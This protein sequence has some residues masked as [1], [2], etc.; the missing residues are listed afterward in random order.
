MNLF[1]SVNIFIGLFCASLGTDSKYP[2]VRFQ[3]ST[4]VGGVISTSKI[5][6]FCD[7]STDMFFDTIA[8]LLI[9]NTQSYNYTLKAS[10]K[11]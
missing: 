7:N 3:Q 10:C 4:K 9:L 2:E 1:A 8:F 11:K 6:I 5:E